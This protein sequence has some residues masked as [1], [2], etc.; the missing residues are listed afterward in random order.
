MRLSPI[1]GRHAVAA[2]LAAAISVLSLAAGAA[3]SPGDYYRV[4]VLDD[5]TSRG[6]PLVELRTRNEVCYYTDSNGI[7]AINAPDMMNHEVLFKISSHGYRYEGAYFGDRGTVLDLKPGGGTTLT[8]HRLNIA[9]RLYRVTGAGIYMDSV[10]T[11]QPVPIRE[12]L[13]CGGVTGQDTVI[14]CPYKGKVFW[15]WGD[16]NG[17]ESFNLSASAAP[18][19]SP[20]KG[21]LDPSVGV[22]LTYFV[23]EKGFSKGVCPFKVRGL[24]WIEGLT[25]VKDAAGRERL[26]GR[27]SS[28]RGLSA[29]EAW[30]FAAFNDEKQEFD[31]VARWD[32]R[33]PHR[34]AHPFHVMAGGREMVYIFP[35]LRVP[36]DFEKMKDLK[37]YEAFTCLEPGT[38]LERG[39]TPR[40]ERDKAG[41]LV[42]GWK[43]ETDPVDEGRL[44]RLVSQDAIKPD[45]AWFQVHD[46]LTGK[47]VPARCGSV[48]WNEFRKRW[49]MIAEEGPGQIWYAEA[50]TPVGPWVYARKV[51]THDRYSFYNPTQHPF[52]DQDGGR[53]IYF[54]GTY[55]EAFSGNREKTPRYDYNQIMY[56]LDLSD[57]RL[58]L[59]APV[60]RVAGDD[61]AEQLMMRDAVE[62]Q[63]LWG[64]V[65][66]V[67][68][69]A[70]PAAAR[71]DGAVEV[72]ATTDKAGTML[73][74]NG[75]GGGEKAASPGETLFMAFPVA[76]ETAAA[77]DEVS[78]AWQCKSTLP[79]GGDIEY[80][81]DLRLRDGKITGTLNMGGEASVE[82]TFADGQITLRLGTEIGAFDIRAKMEQGTL[83]GEWRRS[84]G[85][86]KGN[87]E[88]RRDEG[89]GGSLASAAEAPLLAFRDSKTE[90]IHYTTDAKWSREGYKRLDSPVCRVWANPVS[91]LVLD[92]DTKPVAQAGR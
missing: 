17:L 4:T 32:I 56:R 61:G 39:Q 63:G 86:E 45:E 80:P 58:A 41:R 16:T 23:N 65:R 71:R 64:K 42:Y 21:G 40:V 15:A 29:A 91:V 27:V 53:L 51:V 36:A 54:E 88:A 38:K 46:V 43:A 81:L 57:P 76:K 20:D 68:F 8:I 12:P 6:V 24:K 74:V 19:S 69:F 1:Q 49:V 55:T 11:G 18:R 90:A 77:G 62:K 35:F 79:D 70:L 2:L 22:D 59:P 34:S 67:A 10:V 28:M 66:D 82:G 50:D 3:S 9:E 31:E 52:F 85:T 48:C 60:Y 7:A 26:V 47:P 33:T 5:A 87:F 75:A 92:Q 89:A 73:S 84:D 44:R 14:T 37:N 78:G 72:R 30:V 13:L 83:R 25:T